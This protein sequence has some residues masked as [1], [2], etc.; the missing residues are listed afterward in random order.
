MSVSQKWPEKWIQ[1][2]NTGDLNSLMDLYADDIEV[3]S[4]FAKLIA[5]GG[6]VKGK[7]NVRAYWGESMRRTPA[8][9]LKLGKVYFGHNAISYI[10]ID[11][12]NREVSETVMFNERGLAIFVIAC[13]DPLK[14]SR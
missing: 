6:V 11:F 7:E 9:S 14:Q 8:D 5:G 10:Y 2:W 12:G 13:L 3:W 1:A 4:P